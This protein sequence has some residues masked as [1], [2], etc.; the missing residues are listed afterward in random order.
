[1]NRSTYYKHFSPKASPRILENQRLRTAILEIYTDSKKRFGAHKIGRRL[2]TEYGINISVGRVYRLMKGMN[3]PKMSTVKPR[4]QKPES[5][6]SLPCPNL[7]KQQFNPQK[8][9]E[10]WV[11]DITYVR[12]GG[13]FAYV[14]AVL[15]LFSRKV[16]AL[17]A[18]ARAGAKLTISALESAFHARRA[19]SGVLFHSDRGTQYTCAEFRRACDRLG[20]VQSFSKKAHPFDKKG[21]LVCLNLF[22]QT[23]TPSNAVAEC[24]FKFLKLEELNRKTFKTL[25][26]LRLSLFEYARF[27]NDRRPHSANGGLTP[28]QKEAAL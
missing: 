3:L 25:E 18:D 6:A 16:I 7:L 5:E 10:A 14:C 23:K 22:R 8:P 20:F 12:V 17:L 13:R 27:Y 24:F 2:Q 26:E 15:D 11:G 1:V 19:P 9:N 4:F 28:N 21:A